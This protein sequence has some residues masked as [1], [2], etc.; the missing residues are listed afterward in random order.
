MK[1]IARRVLAVLLIVMVLVSALYVNSSAAVSQP[2]ANW[3]TRHEVCDT[4][5]GSDAAAYYSGGYDYDTLSA[6]SSSA[7][8]TKL[9]TLMTSTHDNES[10]YD[11]CRD[12]A[13][14]T[15]TQG[16]TSGSIVMIYTSYEGTYGEYNS[17][18]GWNREHVWPKSLGGFDEGE[19]AYSDL[20]HIRPSEAKTNSTRNNRIYGNVDT[21]TEVYGN[22]SSELGGYYGSGTNLYEP[23]DNVKGDVAR[24]CLYMYVRYGGDSS[25]TCS[26]LFDS[27]NGV[28]E[29]LETLLQW[30]ELDPVDTWEMGRNDVVEDVQGNRNIFIDYPEYAW[31]LFDQEVPNDMTTPSGEAMG[32][33]T[34]SESGS[35]S[36]S[37]GDSGDT[38]AGDSTNDAVTSAEIVFEFGENGAAGHKDGS[39]AGT[40]ATFTEGD[41]TLTLTDMSKVFKN[42]YDETGKS[43][44]KLGTSS[45]VGTFTFTVPDEVS[46]VIIKVAQ[47]KAKTTTVSVNGT[48]YSITTSS[49]SGEYTDIEIDTTTT[50]TITFATVASNYRAMVDSITYV[51]AASSEG[52]SGEG[53][54][55]ETPE[56]PVDPE[57]ENPEDPEA[58][59]TPSNHVVFEF[60]DNGE[61][62][63]HKDS[64]SA[65]DASDTFTSVCG[66]YTFAFDAAPTKVY[67]SHD[68][69][70]ISAL[71]LGTGS[72]IGSFSF[73]VPDNVT[74]VIIKVAQYK[75][76][77]TT[78][79]IN[80]EQY[81]IET[82]SDNGEYTAITV[83]T[84]TVKTVTVATVASTY[85]AMI[86]SVTYVLAAD[87]ENGIHVE[88]EYGY[89]FECEAGIKSVG[90]VLSTDLSFR[91]GVMVADTLLT[92]GA[93]T[94][95]FTFDGV[96]TVITEY[97]VVNGYYTFVFDGIAPNQMTEMLSADFYLGEELICSM[98]NYS[99]EQNCK[100]LM[101]QYPTDT[102]LIQLLNDVLIYGRY[103]QEFTGTNLE[104][105]AGTDMTLT[106]FDTAPTASDAMSIEGN[107]DAT[108]HISAIGVHFD[109]M[110]SIYVKAYIPDLSSF[111]KIVFD[112]TEYTTE[113]EGVFSLGGGYYQFYFE[114]MDATDF[115]TVH[116]IQLVGAD[117]TVYTTISYSINAYAYH[118]YSKGE[119][120]DAAMYNLA[121]ALYRYGKSAEDYV[122]KKS[123]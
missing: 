62:G 87:C 117:S 55:G 108:L 30:C 10:S 116:T 65:L 85:R 121:L 9:R 100:D 109:S 51:I 99:V 5:S 102:A 33:A 16:G 11:N 107:T 35:G 114:P 60:G 112:S 43:A 64:T 38:G 41:Y 14:Y 4:F 24:I 2:A 23:L 12:Y 22:L 28:F 31:L 27:T 106:P 96:E 29:S 90:L 57:P 45:V 63:T 111:G 66:G 93:L 7:L 56:T 20:H 78:V 18:N 26:D 83:D 94:M 76:N 36:T 58:S 74:S 110:N 53:A 32:I 88:N 42:A 67:T 71:K 123:A 59:E 77:A 119:A 69:T 44:L 75:A 21:K 115:D 89:C 19:A 86:D 95:K 118:M 8:L 15:D 47:Y 48:T 34:D 80:G 79:D 91:Y 103:S 113:S 46:S 17:G 52:D 72:A 54:E 122:L 120:A 81:V 104:S 73:T 97:N 6:L 92:K 98:A 105:V 61:G 13:P 3:G 50:K 70:G 39:D 82:L 1:S 25:Y 37:G 68:K 40:S 84:A 49:D 101:A